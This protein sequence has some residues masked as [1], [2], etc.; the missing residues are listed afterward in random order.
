MN[1]AITVSKEMAN[2]FWEQMVGSY[3]GHM[4]NIPYNPVIDSMVRSCIG[5]AEYHMRNNVAD[6]LIALG[7]KLKEPC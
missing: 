2:L 1:N 3:S 5:H 6:L 4:S 7:N